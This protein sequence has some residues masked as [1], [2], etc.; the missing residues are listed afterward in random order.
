MS[1]SARPAEA[2]PARKQDR[3]T[4]GSRRPAI[5]NRS[6]THVYSRT[7]SASAARWPPQAER[8]A[9]ATS[10]P[11]APE[12]SVDELARQHRVSRREL[13]RDFRRWLGIAPAGCA[14]LVRF[15][16][17]ARAIADGRV[18][19]LG[20]MRSSMSR[21]RRFASSRFAARQLRWTR[22]FQ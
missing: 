7:A 9:A 10:L 8:V 11:E 2:W 21:P 6:S 17:A 16:C 18:H 1:R 3:R 15:Q 20:R 19:R 5:N 4:G 12:L 13:E 22:L 14:R